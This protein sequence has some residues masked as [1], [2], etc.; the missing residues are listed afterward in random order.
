MNPK[1][2]KKDEASHLPEDSREYEGP[3]GLPEAAG[4]TKGEHDGPSGLPH[5]AG[6]SDKG[7][8]G[9]TGLPKAA[10]GYHDETSEEN[11]E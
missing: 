4:G 9:P 6:G 11:G 10:G 3:S 5:E 8:A 7:Q 1:H 2:H